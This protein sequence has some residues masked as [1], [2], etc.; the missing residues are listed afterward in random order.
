MNSFVKAL[1]VVV[2]I[3]FLLAVAAGVGGYLWFKNNKDTLIESGK[4][5]IEEGSR[6]GAQTDSSGCL[7]EA[8][9]RIKKDN[10]IKEQIKIGLFLRGCL[11]ASKLTPGFCDDVP[12]TD[13][14]TKSVTWRMQIAQK[15]KLDG[16][17]ANILQS[18]QKYCDECRKQ[19]K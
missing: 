14:F 4:A 18:V 1:L 7:E 9:A 5:V 19:T 11:N 8:V 10:G 2:S 12:S 17:S 16:N 15:Y 6:L 13:E 3:I